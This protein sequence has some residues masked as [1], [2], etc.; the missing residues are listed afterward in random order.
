M[1]LP[2]LPGDYTVGAVGKLQEPAQTSNGKSTYHFVQGDVHDFAW[3]AAKGY[4]TL[5][6]NWQGP[7]SPQVDVQ[8][9]YPEE[10]EASARPALQAT[11]DSLAF[12]SKSLGAYPYET[13]TV[14]IPPYNAAEAGGMEYPTFFTA[15]GYAKVEPGTL[16]QYLLDFVTIHEFGHGYF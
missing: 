2:I 8:V 15:S 11:I 3:V 1:A 5:D 9:I 4:R 13:V 14:V 6:G 12:F 16:T 7:G 10:Y